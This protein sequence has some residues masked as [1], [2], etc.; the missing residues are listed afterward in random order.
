[1]LLV[2]AIDALADLP[3]NKF[4]EKAFE[5]EMLTKWTDYKGILCF[6]EGRYLV[7]SKPENN[8]NIIKNFTVNT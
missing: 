4:L 6:P 3:E 7:R 5:K 8:A 2:S 1:M